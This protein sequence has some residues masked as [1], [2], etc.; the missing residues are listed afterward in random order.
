MK[1]DNQIL[2]ISLT[3]FDGEGGAPAGGAPAT[4]TTGSG[5]G[6][7]ATPPD[8]GSGK[9]DQAPDKNAEKRRTEYAKFK[10]A[11]KDLYGAD[12]K[13]Q[14][15]DRLKKFK[16]LEQQYSTLN[17][18]VAEI[19]EL[20]GA[21]DLAEAKA[22]LAK[23]RDEK[24][25]DEAYSKGKDP[26]EYR[27]EI[28]RDRKAAAYDAVQKRDAFARN[29]VTQW[30]AQSIELGKTYKDFNLQTVSS[31][32]AILEMLKAGHPMKTAYETV[33]AATI[34]AADPEYEGFDFASWQP[35]SV[36]KACLDNGCTVKNAFESSNLDWTKQAAAKLAEKRTIDTIKG[37]GRIPE[38]GGQK[39]KGSK[40]TKGLAQYTPEQHKQIMD[41]ILAGRAK[42]SDYGM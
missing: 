34:L 23:Q 11:N 3:H 32:P 1:L 6:G 31:N 21:K 42:A 7:I 24:I 40:V 18:E 26:K 39:P 36:F 14:I 38:L 2:N 5:E 28:E 16:P 15:D 17:T 27:E 33:N 12:V 19:L 22:I 25:E 10:E 13:K 41:D 4:G 37:G 8:G 9:P 35:D 30:Q 29:M 20:T